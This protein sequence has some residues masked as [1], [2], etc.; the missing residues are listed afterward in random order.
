MRNIVSLSLTNTLLNDS[1]FEMIAVVCKGTLRSLDISK[2]PSLT[3]KTYNFIA[4]NFRRLECL[5][6]ERNFIKDEGCSALLTWTM[7]SDGV[8]QESFY[9]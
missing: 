1:G 2:N 3:P 6:V 9:S 7:K 4:V 5:N 8:E